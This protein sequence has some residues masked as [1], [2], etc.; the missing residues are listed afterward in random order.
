MVFLNF[1]FYHFNVHSLNFSLS[2]LIF[3]HHSHSLSWT[4]IFHILFCLIFLNTYDP[5]LPESYLTTQ[6]YTHSNH[7]DCSLCPTDNQKCVYWTH[8]IADTTFILQQ[9]TRFKT[10]R[11]TSSMSGPLYPRH[12]QWAEDPQVFLVRLVPRFLE[13]IASGRLSESTKDEAKSTEGNLTNKG[14]SP[15]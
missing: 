3:H 5:Y 10:R 6:T 12:S 11:N 9:V 8:Y 7:F 14:L 2:C 4:G 13:P 1:L 15:N